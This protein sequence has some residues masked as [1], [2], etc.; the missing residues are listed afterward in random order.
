MFDFV[1]K[2]S[3]PLFNLMMANTLYVRALLKHQ[4]GLD[5]EMSVFE[6]EA[7]KLFEKAKKLYEKNNKD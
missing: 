6:S 3:A 1:S 2:I 4:Q 7:D 5:S